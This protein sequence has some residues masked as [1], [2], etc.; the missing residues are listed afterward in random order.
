M[1]GKNIEIAHTLAEYRRR[2]SPEFR[3]A[4]DAWL[5][6][7]PFAQPDEPPD[8]LLCPNTTTPC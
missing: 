1:E 6:A 4:F 8:P 5:K 7:Q 3:V 2:F